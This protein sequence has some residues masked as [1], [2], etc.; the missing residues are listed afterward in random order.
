MDESRVVTA[1]G[2]LSLDENQEVRPLLWHPDC[3][4]HDNFL[5]RLSTRFVT[6]GKQAVFISFQEV[7]GRTN[8]TKEESGLL[9]LVLYSLVC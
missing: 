5:F 7:I 1:F 2:Q 8:V 9:T 3:L 4:A 6:M